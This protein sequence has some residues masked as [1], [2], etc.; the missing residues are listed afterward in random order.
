M[1]DRDRFR[2]PS[3]REEGTAV[4]AAETP[5]SGG[6]TPASESEAPRLGTSGADSGAPPPDA[7]APGDDGEEHSVRSMLR[8]VRLGVGHDVDL[9]GG[10]QRRIRERS[11]G[12]FYRDGWSRSG[13]T[14]STHVLT[15]LLML[16]ILLL[17][18]FV[19][20]PGMRFP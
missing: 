4:P 2:S 12:R 13:S 7:P 9:L 14:T 16:V 3:K 8:G 5:A 20:L 15:S 17:V 1:T 19:L 10:V 6:E 11:R 18:Y